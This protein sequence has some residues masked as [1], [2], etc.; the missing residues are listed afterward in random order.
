[1][2]SNASAVGLFRR[3]STAM[4][5]VMGSTEGL[6]ESWALIPHRARTLDQRA[7]AQDRLLVQQ[8]RDE[9]DVDRKVL[10]AHPERHREAG[11]P[12]QIKWRGRPHDLGGGDPLAINN[13]FLQLM[14]WCRERSD[15]AQ[16]HVVPL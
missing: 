16:Q 5:M 12:R 6:G 15:G 8:S 13:V 7:Q 10:R 3:A 1:M 2:R 11:Q 4:S 9:L 14:G